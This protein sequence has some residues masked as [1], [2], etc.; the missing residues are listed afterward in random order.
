MRSRR[1]M[2]VLVIEKTF[3]EATRYDNG[4]TLSI[5]S[6]DPKFSEERNLYQRYVMALNFLLE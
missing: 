3:L 6:D 2:E 4:E 1:V 5:L